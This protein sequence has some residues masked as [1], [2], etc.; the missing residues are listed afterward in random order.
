MKNNLVKQEG[1]KG[2]NF[3][4]QSKAKTWHK[5]QAFIINIFYLV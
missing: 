5:K 4:S 1:R 2:V 3:I